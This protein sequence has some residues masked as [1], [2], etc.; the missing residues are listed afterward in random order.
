MRSENRF[1]KIV[2]L[3]TAGQAEISFQLFYKEL[4]TTLKGDSAIGKLNES[5]QPDNA[6]FA[7]LH[8]INLLRHLSRIIFKG[9]VVERH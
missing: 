6:S 7:F 2:I 8:C 1:N 5:V 4:L 9:L 3:I